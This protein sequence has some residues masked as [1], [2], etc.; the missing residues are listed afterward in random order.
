MCVCV[1]VCIYRHTHTHT[2]GRH[3]HSL[4]E[5]GKCDLHPHL[6]L[7]GAGLHPIFPVGVDG[8]R[9]HLYK[10][11]EG[12]GCPPS[13]RLERY[14]GVS[15]HP[16]ISM[17]G[18]KAWISTSSPLRGWTPP[19]HLCERCKGVGCPTPRLYERCRGVVLHFLFSIGIKT[20]LRTFM[21]GVEGWVSTHSGEGPT[22]TCVG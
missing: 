6:G 1:Y 18:K 11:R 22:S 8:P 10:K 5:K 9:P 12:V 17:G 13:R 2:H 19:S 3:G 15:L 7:E 20:Y 21:K 4:T 16:R 14:R